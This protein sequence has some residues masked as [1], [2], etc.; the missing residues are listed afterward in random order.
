M[1]GKG[2]ECIASRAYKRESV[3]MRGVG[4]RVRTPRGVEREDTAV[5][6]CGRDKKVQLNQ[7][8]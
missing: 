2:C 5:K 3:C 7:E 4:M 1:E 8:E 6:D